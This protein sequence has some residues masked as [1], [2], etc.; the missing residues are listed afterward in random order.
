[1]KDIEILGIKPLD[2]LHISCA[3]EANC[4]FFI[5]V[6]KGILKKKNKIDYISIISPMDFINE[7][8]EK[9]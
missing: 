2:A 7:Q 8:E 4:D 3:V 6:D 1:M 5:T 9:R